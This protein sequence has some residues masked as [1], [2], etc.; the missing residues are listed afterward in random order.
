MIGKKYVLSFLMLLGLALGI[1]H[2]AQAC[3]SLHPA[4]LMQ[5]VG[6]VSEYEDKGKLKHLLYYSNTAR[7]L[8]VGPNAMILPIPAIPNSMS[9]D[10]MFDGRQFRGIAHDLYKSCRDTSSALLDSLDSVLMQ[11][12][13]VSNGM[14]SHVH[15]EVFNKGSYT[16]V[17]SNS[18][19]AIPTALQRVPEEKRPDL[20]QAIFDAYER[21][22]PGW[23]FALCCFNNNS[24]AEPQEPLVW[25]YEPKNPDELF[26]PAVDCHTG[27]VPPLDG[28][29]DVDHCLVASSG[30]ANLLAGI[31]GSAKVPDYLPGL[32]ESKVLGPLLPDLASAHRYRGSELQGDFVFNTQDVRFGNFRPFRKL[33]PGVPAANDDWLVDGFYQPGLLMNLYLVST[34]AGFVV[35]FRRAWLLGLAMLAAPWILGF[36]FGFSMLP[37]KPGTALAMHD[38]EMQRIWLISAYVLIPS[39]LAP[40][41]RQKLICLGFSLLLLA[42]FFAFPGGTTV[43]WWGALYAAMLFWGFKRTVANPSSVSEEAP[44]AAESGSVQDGANDL[45]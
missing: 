45:E 19:K 24:T 6:W 30:K 22:Y 43:L 10:N 38:F 5:T 33:P 14:D 16:V 20:N 8:G 44:L 34:F 29:V 27:A 12:N 36:A 40:S 42:L 28:M 2:Q 11:T 37:S 23:T 26:F 4:E 35:L 18:A 7:N 39:L 31:I 32:K 13:S 25:W 21:W 3:C 41:S 9:Q 15:I 1:I 17:L